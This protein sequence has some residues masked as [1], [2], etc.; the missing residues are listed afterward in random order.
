M[1]VPLPLLS[2]LWLVH[3]AGEPSECMKQAAW[4]EAEQAE[5]TTSLLQR[6]AAPLIREAVF[7][8]ACG[9]NHEQLRPWLDSLR[10]TGFEGMVCLGVSSEMDPVTDA[11]LT[12]HR[13]VRRT[14]PCLEQAEQAKWTWLFG[15]HG[16]FNH[17]KGTLNQRRWVHYRNWLREFNADKVWMVDVRDIVFQAN[18]FLNTQPGMSFFAAREWSSPTLLERVQTCLGDMKLASELDQSSFPEVSGGSVFGQGPPLDNFLDMMSDRIELIAENLSNYTASTGDTSRSWCMK[19]DQYVLVTL[20]HSLGAKSPS[21]QDSIRVFSNGD[22]V[23]STILYDRELRPLDPVTDLQRCGSAKDRIV[24]A[25][26]STITNE[27][28]HGPKQQQ[29]HLVNKHSLPYVLVHRWDICPFTYEMVMGVPRP[30]G[31]EL[32][33]LGQR[34]KVVSRV[35]EGRKRSR[36]RRKRKHS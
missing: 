10:G 4:E 36:R 1:A 17:F 13:V 33:G 30:K 28:A 8:M 15:D 12:S 31:L 5:G 32:F 29:M 20:A 18:P 3:V 16:D 19:T 2:L 21:L 34:R 23:V 22:G 9:F 14:E 25:P 27:A 6:G 11:F 24:P 7:G 26:P 35:Q